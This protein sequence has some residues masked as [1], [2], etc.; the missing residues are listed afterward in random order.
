MQ[1]RSSKVVL[2]FYSI[3]DDKHISICIS[4]VQKSTGLAKQQRS[5]G[6]LIVLCEH[7]KKFFSVFLNGAHGE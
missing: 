6:H 2:Q 5:I 4:C 3:S 1:E 7:I